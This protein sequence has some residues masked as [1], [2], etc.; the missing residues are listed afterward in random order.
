MISYEKEVRTVS[1]SHIDIS[2]C[3]PQIFSKLIIFI[4]PLNLDTLPTPK[5]IRINATKNMSTKEP[6]LCI[7]ITLLALQ[8]HQQQKERKP[9]T[10]T[11]IFLALVLILCIPCNCF[12]NFP[13]S[14]ASPL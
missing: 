11:N 1:Y 3:F 14:F 7:T 4:L 10:A 9:Y 5:R 6:N 8:T 2:I 12:L 13:S